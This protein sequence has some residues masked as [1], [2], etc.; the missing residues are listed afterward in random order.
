MI[1]LFANARLENDCIFVML[2][3]F[4]PLDLTMPASG[5]MMEFRGPQKPEVLMLSYQSW[6]RQM[7]KACLWLLLG[8]AAFLCAGR[9]CAVLGTLALGLLL[10]CLPL[11]F[12][13]SW[14]PACNAVL[15]GW[16]FALILWLLL[17]FARW[18]ETKE[19]ELRAESGEGVENEGRTV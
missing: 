12:A 16:M 5:R 8:I 11:A 19:K 9:H 3:E 18:A 15:A 10:T 7:L 17:R 1:H 2:V 4:L 14:L 6:E 13:L